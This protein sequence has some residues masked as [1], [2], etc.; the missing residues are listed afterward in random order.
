MSPTTT[1]KKSGG[2]TFAG[3]GPEVAGDTSETNRFILVRHNFTRKQFTDA[4]SR[5]ERR[6]NLS[7]ELR[8]VLKNLPDQR[9]LEAI[10]HGDF[11]E[12]GQPKIPALVFPSDVGGPLNGSNL[13]NRHF[14]PC[15]EAAGLRRVTMHA[16]RQT[17][18]SLLN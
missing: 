4:K 5:K 18:A 2:S 6:V 3:A 17:F 16:L 12:R 11:D 15:L 13:Y 9:I 1:L 10:E 7:R 8:Q 14:L